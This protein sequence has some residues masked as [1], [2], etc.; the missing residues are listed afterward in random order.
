MLALY[1]MNV[2]LIIFDMSNQCEKLSQNIQELYEKMVL[3]KYPLLADN[4]A[5]SSLYNEETTAV[6][7]NITLFITECVIIAVV[8]EGNRYYLSLCE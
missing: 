4:G 2:I 3:L 6:E 1:C 8:V 7:R 5:W